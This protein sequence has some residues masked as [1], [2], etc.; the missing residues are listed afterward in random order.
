[1]VLYLTETEMVYWC[2]LGKRWRLRTSEA[3]GQ[4]DVPLG[5][6]D[7]ANVEAARNAAAAIRVQRWAT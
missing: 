7:P 2:R 4:T 6:E 3:H 5:V 1:M